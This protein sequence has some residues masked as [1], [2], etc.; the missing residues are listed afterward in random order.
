M[1]RSSI[2]EIKTFLGVKF[3]NVSSIVYIKTHKKHSIVTT[4][5]N[6]PFEA[7]HSIGWFEKK[8]DLHNFS[9]CHNSYIVN[10]NFINCLNYTTKTIFLRD[11]VRVPFSRNRKQD[12]ISKIK[13]IDSFIV[14]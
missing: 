11:D 5:I 9:R 4:C 7:F 3:I 13:L 14:I 1:V 10:I 12:L 6:P 8:F 2:I